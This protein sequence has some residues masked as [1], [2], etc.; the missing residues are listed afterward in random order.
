MTALE[1]ATSV[2]N[3]KPALTSCSSHRSAAHSAELQR[4][5][6]IARA[7]LAAV[8]EIQ[9]APHGAHCRVGLWDDA[10]CEPERCWKGAALLALG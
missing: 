8:E 10:K 4:E 5:E 3:G 9:K 6:I 7:L 2:V 1:H